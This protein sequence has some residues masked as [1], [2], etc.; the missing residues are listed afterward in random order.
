MEIFE[1]FASQALDDLP[2][3]VIWLSTDLRYTWVNKKYLEYYSGTAGEVIGRHARDQVGE[4]RLRGLLE[5]PLGRCLQGESAFA[6]GWVEYPVAGRRFMLQS[7]VPAFDEKGKV[8]QILA[9]ARDITDLKLHE[10]QLALRAAEEQ[11]LA[12]LGKMALELPDFH[13]YLQRLTERI[14]QELDIELVKVLEMQHDT[15]SLLLVAGVGWK[16]GLVG[17]ATVPGRDRSQAGYTMMTDRP[18]VQLDWSRENR[19]HKPDLLKDHDVACGVS[20]RIGGVQAPYGILAVHSRT[21]RTFRDDQIAF[22]VNAT[23]L[24]AEAV[25]RHRAV[26]T[27]QQA[28]ERY[29]HLLE[30]SPSVIY[31]TEID[32][33]RCVFITENFRQMTGHDPALMIGSSKFWFDSLHPDDRQRMRTEVDTAIRN[34]EGVFRYRFRHAAGYYF[35]I[36]DRFHVVRDRGGKPVEVVGAWTDIS[37]DVAQ[38]EMVKSSEAMLGYIVDTITDAIIVVDDQFR[39]VVFNSAAEKLFGTTRQKMAGRDV[40]ELIPERFREIHRQHMK[41]FAE[42]PTAG[43]MGPNRKIY[44]LRADG[45]EFPIEACISRARLPRRMLYTVVLRAAV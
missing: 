35:W 14:A 27:L 40:H 43:R 2:D 18:V 32:G 1:R 26:Q 6:Q 4:E 17:K 21:P 42:R 25:E 16:E 19:F 28:R 23:N 3:L 44:G 34:G 13:E 15:D 9:F 8:V 37:E 36:E 11:A 33:F 41:A 7:A 39:V 24:I 5:G 20:V 45:E 22:L 31:A 10:D 12:E 29:R 38:D 30:S